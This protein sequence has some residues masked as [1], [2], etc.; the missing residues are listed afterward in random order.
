MSPLTTPRDSNREEL[1]FGSPLGDLPTKPA[2]AT[3]AFLAPAPAASSALSRRPES[4]LG[5][6][7]DTPRVHRGSPTKAALAAAA[8]ATNG[9]GMQ[10]V[11]SAHG[12]QSVLVS[13]LE[14]R[15]PERR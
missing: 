2:A 15:S 10:R 3:A 5:A 13:G 8:A 14:K 1:P 9:D 4:T 12:M 7:D 6:R 11:V